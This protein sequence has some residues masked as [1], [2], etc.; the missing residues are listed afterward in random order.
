MNI[1]ELKVV[2][3]IGEAPPPENGISYNNRRYF[4]LPVRF[5]GGRRIEFPTT[6]SCELM[7]S[8]IGKHR[9]RVIDLHDPAVQEAIFNETISLEMP[10]LRVQLG[11]DKAPKDRKCDNPECP[12]NCDGK[13]TVETKGTPKVDAKKKTTK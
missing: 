10:N 3:W 8:L 12:P 6:G 11:I 9:A 2:E 13:H 5:M 1:R 4:F 7:A